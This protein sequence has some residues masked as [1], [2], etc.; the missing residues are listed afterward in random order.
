MKTIN[1]IVEQA[2]NG[3]TEIQVMKSK[4]PKYSF[5]GAELHREFDGLR[6]WLVKIVYLRQT[7][8]FRRRWTRNFSGNPTLTR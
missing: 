7:F 8:L 2:Q 5:I 3:I 4:F 1:Q 6:R